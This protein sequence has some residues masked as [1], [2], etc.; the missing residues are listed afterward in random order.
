MEN[1]LSIT[2]LE[3]AFFLAGCGVNTG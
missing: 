1:Y 2:A 3:V